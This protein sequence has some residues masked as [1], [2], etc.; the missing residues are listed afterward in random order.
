MLVYYWLCFFIASLLRS[1]K[2]FAESLRCPAIKSSARSFS[3]RPSYKQVI[4]SHHLSALAHQSPTRTVHQIPAAAAAQTA[5]H[6]L[7]HY[8][9]LRQKAADVD[10]PRPEAAAHPILL[11][12]L[13][14]PEA[15]VHPTLQI[16]PPRPEAAAQ[17]LLQILP[18]RQTLPQKVASPTGATC[19]ADKDSTAI[20]PILH[21]LFLAGVSDAETR[22]QALHQAVHRQKAIPQATRLKIRLPRREDVRSFGTSPTLAKSAFFLTNIQVD[23]RKS[24]PYITKYPIIKSHRTMIFILLLECYFVIAINLCTDMS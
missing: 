2:V 21:R 24:Q 20:H 17:P 14:R 22:H 18:L 7:L 3:L 23:L 4:T 1:Q 19:S 10:P 9:A 16:L 8:L 6:P 11:I 15:S 12:L 13:P 5:T